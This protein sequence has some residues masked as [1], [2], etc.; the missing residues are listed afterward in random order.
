[1]KRLY[2]VF[3]YESYYVASGNPGNSS[4]PA[5]THAETLVLIN[6]GGRRTL[7][8]QDAYFDI[9]YSDTK[10]G[11]LDYFQMLHL[12]RDGKH[13]DVRII[14][15]SD[16]EI[17]RDLILRPSETSKWKRFRW[18]EISDSY[19]SL[20]EQR[21]LYRV[22]FSLDSFAKYH[23]G[24]QNFKEMLVHD[25][26]PRNLLYIHLYP[27]QVDVY[28]L[29]DLSLASNS[30]STAAGLGI[31]KTAVNISNGISE[32]KSDGFGLLILMLPGGV[33]LLTVFVLIRMRTRRLTVKSLQ[34]Q[35]AALTW[36]ERYH[37]QT[38]ARPWHLCNEDI[39]LGF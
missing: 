15:S 13:E 4:F 25:G 24:A 22:A 28:T 33:I 7:S 34:S 6:W 38:A 17:T 29:Q 5:L 27:F 35:R 31:L 12:L 21:S 2:E 11:P 39:Y 36:T 16:S 14:P 20:D 26:Y 10:G 32:G 3:G 1:M 30:T 37:N 9:S 8:V 19:V 18:I 23:A